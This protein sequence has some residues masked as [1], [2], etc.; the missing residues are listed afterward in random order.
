[1]D[2]FTKPVKYT[3]GGIDPFKWF[4]IYYKDNKCRIGEDDIKIINKDGDQTTEKLKNVAILFKDLTLQRTGETNFNFYDLCSFSSVGSNYASAIPVALV[5]C[6]ETWNEAY[7]HQERQNH[8]LTS[9]FKKIGLSQPVCLFD[10]NCNEDEYIRNQMLLEQC[11]RFWVSG[12]RNDIDNDLQHVSNMYICQ[13]TSLIYYTF[14]QILKQSFGNRTEIVENG[15]KPYFTMIYLHMR[16]MYSAIDLYEEIK[17]P[18][19]AL[20][21]AEFSCDVFQR[22]VC[23]ITMDRELHVEDYIKMLELTLKRYIKRFNKL[24]NFMKHNVPGITAILIFSPLYRKLCREEVSLDQFISQFINIYNQFYNKIQNDSENLKDNTDIAKHY[25]FDLCSYSEIDGN[26]SYKNISDLVD[27]CKDPKN[28]LKSFPIDGLV[29]PPQTDFE[30]SI[31][32]LKIRSHKLLNVCRIREEKGR[33]VLIAKNPADWSGIILK[34]G[35]SY[36]FTPTV[37]GVAKEGRFNT[38]KDHMT[39]VVSFTIG[40]NILPNYKYHVSSAGEILTSINKSI[41]SYGQTLDLKKPFTLIVKQKNFTVEQDNKIFYTGETKKYKVLVTFKYV[42]L[43]VEFKPDGF[44]IIKRSFNTLKRMNFKKECQ[45]LDE[46]QSEIHLNDF[47]KIDEYLE[48]V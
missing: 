40:N 2:K 23:A 27:F 43:M 45:K 4:K 8:V 25:I 37:L 26:I 41:N 14:E 29:K 9:G 48:T 12:G 42:K 11:A 36:K 32:D 30:F 16:S 35:G 21:D 5:S 1:M 18:M 39:A 38:R 17:K 13:Q 28:R 3:T 31:D 24:K 19:E 47:I 7:M 22:T 6:P 34:S 33:T 44:E 20:A 10:K 15:I 46:K